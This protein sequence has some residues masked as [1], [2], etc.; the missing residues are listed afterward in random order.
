MK[1]WSLALLLTGLCACTGNILKNSTDKS[2]ADITFIE[3]VNA[4]E[5]K[6]VIPYKKYILSNGLTLVLHEDS[7]DPLVH[8][9]VTYHVGSAREEMGKS[10]FAHFFEHMMFQ[11]SE[12]V[13]DEQH[14]KI[15]TEAGGSMNGT[16]NGDR[17]NYFQTVP[18]NQLEKM[19]WLESDRMGYLL[20]AVTQEKFEV[21]RETVKNERGQSYENRPY[22]LLNER[23]A[24]ALYP[25]GHPY[26]W[27]TIGY[28]ED[29]NRVNVND[30]K[31]FFLRWYG[32]NN[33]TITIGGDIDV[34][35]TL[36]LVK[37]YF[38]DIPR[39]PEVNMPTATSFVIDEDRY[40]SME[41][42]V[43]L[44]L[45][46]MSYP[47]VKVRHEDE[48]P[49]DLLSTILGGGKTSLLYKN[50]VKN[51]LAVQ[52]SVS[53][54]CAELACTFNMYALPHPNSEKSLGDIEKIIRDTL[55]EFET[56]GVEDD[57]LTKAKAAMEASFIFGLQSVKG[58][59]SQLAANQ[60]FKNNPNYI[61]KDIARY[62]NV[63]KAD[64]MRVYQKYLKNKSGVIM[65]VVPQ[66]QLATIAAPNNFEPPKHEF[67]TNSDTS[68]DDLALRKSPVTFD[69]S[70]IPQALESKSV[71]LPSMWQHTMKN[72]LRVL[73]T[74]SDETPTTSLLIKVP[75]GHYFEAKE[76]AGL[77]SLLASLLNESTSQRSAEE[78]SKALQMLG[79]SLSIS[80][81][82]QYVYINV[83]TL[84]K[85]LDATMALVQE[86][87]T[88]PAFLDEEFQRKKNN[89]IQS[90]I[91]N[92]KNAGYLA[93]YAYRKLLQA[94]NIAALPLSGT[95]ET[96]SNIQLIDI[97]RFYETN[98]KPANGQVIAVS[99]LAKKELMP[100]FDTLNSWK[101]EAKALDIS[102]P[103]P[104]VK[105][106][107]I[108]IVN[109]S[110]AAQSAIRIGK[111]SLTYDVAGDFYR[112]NLMNFA[113]GG[114]FNSRINLNLRENKGYT[115]GAR[116]YFGGD[117]FSG[118][119]TA[120]SE[121]RADVTDKA[122]IEFITEIRTYVEKGITEEELKFM[123]S[124]INQKDA[125]KYE[126]PDAK[127]GF[128]GQILEYNLTPNFVTERANI[129]DNISAQEINALAKKHLQVKD[130][131]IVVVGDVKTLKPK[132]SELGYD[133][134]EYAIP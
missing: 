6:T 16:T 11:G 126:T 25:K 115:Y 72:G 59:V 26:S 134:V 63:T 32:P 64:V 53:H 17:T 57:D 29:L 27:Q 88:Q 23:V 82:N 110:D 51:Q 70:V 78:M 45:L 95:P 114:D 97:K 102:L 44:P 62:A 40:I 101:G 74:E 8:V 54:P 87:I 106:G 118:V 132:L 52:A 98:F 103:E 4:V 83:N 7:S 77:V 109:K 41:D 21:Q 94:D 122:I 116:S 76:Q 35:K 81:S 12:H 104:D 30:L 69:R 107:V 67:I 20:N 48:A 133:V 61:E 89:A 39:G 58:K 124:A 86:K 36:M 33:A 18:S 92:Q 112:A 121:V 50:L 113:L 56:R 15:V 68:V 91:N 10:G 75:V 129:V 85:H 55:L 96:L 117:I 42:N 73:A 128:L 9:D 65:S 34:E 24:Q 80:A 130:M 43:H 90:V 19:L 3:E 108:Y 60:T 131:I 2:A 5:G 28:I 49:L 84:T 111:R 13:A 71:E 93:S 66:G 99:N 120:S 14:F 37:Q 47:T 100:Y 46:Y 105:T 79:A 119:F 38:G 125:L 22:G 31:A 123:R 1:I 127:L